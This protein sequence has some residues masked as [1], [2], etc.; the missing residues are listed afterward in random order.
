M[1]WIPTLC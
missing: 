1:K